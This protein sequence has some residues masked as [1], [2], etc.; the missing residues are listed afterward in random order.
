MFYFH[1]TSF[2]L[3]SVFAASLT[4]CSKG[5]F[6]S[7]PDNIQA[8]LDVFS[9]LS[10][11]HHQAMVM[12]S[13]LRDI[14]THAEILTNTTEDAETLQSLAKKLAKARRQ[15]DDIKELTREMSELIPLPEKYSA[16]SLR[17]EPETS[18][19]ELTPTDES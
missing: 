18:S 2:L 11:M 5:G 17:R 3:A 6:E 4:G 10:E 16:W 15:K 12:P 1:K 7:R 9:A 19:E 14:I 8:R 13:Y